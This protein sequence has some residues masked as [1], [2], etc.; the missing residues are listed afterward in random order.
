MASRP[1]RTK[2]H[3]TVSLNTVKPQ[4][5]LCHDIDSPLPIASASIFC[6]VPSSDFPLPSVPRW[7]IIKEYPGLK[8]SRRCFPIVR[9]VPHYLPRY[10]AIQRPFYRRRKKCDMSFCVPRTIRPPAQIAYRRP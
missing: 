2:L 5:G 9:I 6:S 3:S 8:W 4:T 10:S 7:D 1:R